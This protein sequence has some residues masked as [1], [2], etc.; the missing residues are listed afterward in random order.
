MIIF[1]IGSNDCNIIN[2]KEFVVS[3]DSFENNL[4]T[5]LE[6]AQKYT[7]KIVFIGQIICDESKTNPLPWAPEMSQDMK[8]TQLYNDATKTFCKENNLV[9][10]DMLDVL[11]TQD[12]EDG[13]HPTAEGHEKMYVR[14]KNVLIEKGFI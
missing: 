7:E 5:L 4:A 10:I 3:L 13:I 9:F 2:N 1:A 14:I 6:K 8:H 11:S 12:L